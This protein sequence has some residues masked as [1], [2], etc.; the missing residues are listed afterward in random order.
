MASINVILTKILGRTP[1]PAD[2]QNET[3]M[4]QVEKV[5]EMDKEFLARDSSVPEGKRIGEILASMQ[6]N[7]V[8]SEKAKA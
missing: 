5:N 2:Y 1:E 3:L 6:A 7:A 8:S 4:K